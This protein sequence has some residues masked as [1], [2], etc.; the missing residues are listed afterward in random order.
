MTPQA[1]ALL[2]YLH[3]ERMNARVTPEHPITGAKLAD[4]FELSSSVEIRSL[5]HECRSEGHW[6]A[7]TDKGYYEALW[8][9]EIA[10]TIRSLNAR[11]RAIAIPANAMRAKIAL[12]KQEELQLC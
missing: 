4:L 10:E 9:H 7:A 3:S 8:P 12:H 1:Q 2:D 11:A 5:V 6:I